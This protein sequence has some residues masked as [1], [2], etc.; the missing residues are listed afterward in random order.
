MNAIELFKKIYNEE[1]KEDEC[2]EVLHPEEEN[3]Y[4]L[5]DKYKRF[6]E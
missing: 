5:R 6:D 1:I 4:L 2:I 3:Y